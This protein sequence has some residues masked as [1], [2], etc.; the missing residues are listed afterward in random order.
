[1][2]GRPSHGSSA[3]PLGAPFPCSRDR[4]AGGGGHDLAVGLTP[5]AATDTLVGRNSAES[6]PGATT[7]SSA[8]TPSSSWSRARC[9]LVLTSDIERVLGLEGCISG[10]L[11]KGVKPRGGRT[12]RARS[13][14]NQAGQGRLRPGDVHQRVGRADLRPVHAPDAPGP[15]AGRAA[16]P[17]RRASSRSRAGCRRRRPTSSPSRRAELR[18]AQFIRDVAQA[19]PQVRAHRPPKLNDP[20]SSHSW[21]SRT[22]SPDAQ[23]ALRL[24]VPDADSALSRCG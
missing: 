21:S 6:A 12:A 14:P 2:V 23:G 19:R 7:R 5:S 18:Q 15:A 20:T 10:N 11:P 3:P 16:W 1:M 17:P 22:R 8:T 24:P 4:G 9:K 13:S